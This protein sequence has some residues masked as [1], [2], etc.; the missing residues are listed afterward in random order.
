MER[1]IKKKNISI[2]LSGK[3]RHWEVETRAEGKGSLG[4]EGW[5]AGFPPRLLPGAASTPASLASP[6][7]L[8]WG[9]RL[10]PSPRLL[11]PFCQLGPS[12]LG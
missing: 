10:L 7:S 1:K 12:W 8:A 11:L 2:G 4:E 5:A 9:R 6:A 3:D